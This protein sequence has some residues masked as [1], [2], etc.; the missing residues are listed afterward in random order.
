MRHN[1]Q[2]GRRSLRA[3]LTAVSVGAAAVVCALAGA[4]IVHEQ[5]R[6]LSENLDDALD[7]RLEDVAQ[8]A[9]DDRL[10]AELSGGEDTALQVLR[11]GAVVASSPRLAG[12]PAVLPPLNGS[13]RLHKTSDTTPIPGSQRVVAQRV[14]TPQGPVTVIV[15]GQ[16]SDITESRQ[17]LT[18]TLAVGVPGLTLLL[19]LGTWL[20]IGRALRPVEAIRSEVASITEGELWR[21]VPTPT[22]GDEIARLADTMNA[23][24]DRVEQA[25]GRQA[26]FVADAS[27]E[28]RTPLTRIRAE[29]EVDLA[30]GSAVDPIATHRSV[31]EETATLE[32]L[33]DQ[34]LVLARGDA[35][36]S[37]PATEVDLDDLVLGAAADLR[38][39]R[40][41]L[42]VDTTHIHPVVVMGWADDL[43]R[44]VANLLENAGRFAITRVELELRVV[45]DDAELT[46]AD[47]GAGIPVQ[48]RDRVFERFT[49]LDGSRTA[50]SGGAGLG[51][52]IVQEI[53]ARHRGSV[54]ISDVRISDVRT[55]DAPDGGG[56]RVVVLLPA[57]LE[58]HALGESRARVDAQ[59]LRL[60]EPQ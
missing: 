58:E 34:L 14:A 48:D 2:L 5:T 43:R 51:L 36:A 12:R 59:Q 42:T 20:L 41:T 16:R 60:G 9:R 46:V 28:L 40:P 35:S 32:R 29:L 22:S 47:D 3:R 17:V 39:R 52:A 19:G 4:L 38:V 18:R 56:C 21:R 8:L 7:Q 53:V 33:V 13:Q 6:L 15:I 27:H 49:R 31:L 25:T 11:G 10:P 30:H 50:S 23:M 45:G 55:G 24:L 44:V 1:R 26:H 37:G 57:A 54:R